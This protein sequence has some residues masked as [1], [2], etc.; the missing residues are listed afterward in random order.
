[1]GPRPTSLSPPPLPAPSAL[2]LVDR[3][4]LDEA[5]RLYKQGW[6]VSRIGRHVDVDGSGEQFARKA[7]G[8]ELRREQER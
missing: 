3:L 5:T 2:G 4:Q 1:M 8:Y 7:Y 6:S